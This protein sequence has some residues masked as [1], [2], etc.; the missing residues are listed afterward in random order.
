MIACESTA[1]ALS[2]CVKRCGEQTRPRE[3]Q[4]IE[5]TALERTALVAEIAGHI[6]A[7]KG[8]VVGELLAKILEELRKVR[9]TKGSK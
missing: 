5:G 1:S 2:E 3:A 8:R 4:E 7:V 9:G 6:L